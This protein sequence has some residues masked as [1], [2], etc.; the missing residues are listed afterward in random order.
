MKDAL[1]RVC[2][3]S[4]RAGIGVALGA[5]SCLANAAGDGAAVDL[6]SLTNGISMASTITA[7]LAVALSLVTVYSTLRGAKIVL[8]AIKGG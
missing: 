7:I 1:Q 5:A 4:S 3:I 8:A 6:S 2:S